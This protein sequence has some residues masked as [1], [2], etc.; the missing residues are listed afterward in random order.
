MVFSSTIF[1]F[2]FLPVVLT[3]CFLLRSI[4]SRNAFLLTASLAF[5]VWGE[6]GYVLVLLAS[7]VTNWAFGLLIERRHKQGGT[8]RN[9]LRLAVAF[10]LLTLISFKYA[11]FIVDNLN[12]ALALLG[13]GLNLGPIMLDPVHLPIG[14]S[15][16]TFQALSYVVDVHRG[17]APAQRS[18]FRV[19]LFISLFPQ[20]IAGPIVRYHQIAAQLSQRTAELD[21]IAAGLRRFVIG[22]GKKVLIANTLA[23]PA[24]AIFSLPASELTPAVAWWG[25]TCFALQIY[26]DF[27]GYSDMAIGIGRCLGFRFPENFDW[28]YLS[29]S[30]RTFWR[31]WH[32]S[33]SSFFRDYVYIPLGGSRLGATR[34]HVNLIAVF[35]LCG[36]WHGAS[37]SFVVW[38][39]MH[40]VFLVLERG[41]LGRL[42]AA[43]PQV[44]RQ[45]YTLSVVLI[46]WVFFR[47]DDLP[48][49]GAYL[50]ALF[51]ARLDAGLHHPFSLYWNNEIVFM[52]VVALT[53]LLPRA[54]NAADRWSQLQSTSTP[55]EL[56]RLAGVLGILILSAM[57]L[58]SGTHNPFIYFRF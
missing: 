36:L 48:H 41:R 47:A 29:D 53:A 12:A 13:P 39:A 17:D 10:N 55:F 27:S 40:G 6:F 22:L 4:R 9:L 45:A 42:L 51:G 46:A 8:A 37:W 5:Y 16:F 54:R 23:I 31:R 3:V 28:P 30:V 21:D 26:F 24:D 57:S 43:S 49:A 32:I 25:V 14:I 33:L 56:V 18:V 7:V 50:A 52:L 34:T 11:N 44:V 58:V 1:L 2:A 19:G 35:L 15:F 20:L 38:G